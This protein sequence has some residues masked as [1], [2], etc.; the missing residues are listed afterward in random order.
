M[1]WRSSASSLLALSCAALLAGC[2][3]RSVGEVQRA[4]SAEG[5]ELQAV[6]VDALLRARPRRHDWG[7]M[8]D[9]GEALFRVGRS[10]RNPRALLIARRS[11]D[12]VGVEI[13]GG[14][15]DAIRELRA[16]S[17]ADVAPTLERIGRIVVYWDA[18]VGPTERA[19][20]RRAIDRLD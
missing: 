13:F 18:G 20:I 17:S 6:D 8:G 4:F 5:I 12:T 15:G 7:R 3:G 1:S 2:G 19:K 10:P 11:D 14:S 9:L 16:A